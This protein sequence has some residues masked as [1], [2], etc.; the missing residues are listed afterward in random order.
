MSSIDNMNIFLKTF[1]AS[2]AFFTLILFAVL[3][4]GNGINKQAINSSPSSPSQLQTTPIPS[5]FV[6][7]GDANVSDSVDFRDVE[8]ISSNWNYSVGGAIDQY[9]DG[10]VNSL[11]FAVVAGKLSRQK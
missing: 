5:V 3:L 1:L 6:G 8:F 10:K 9:Q 7:N 11:D 2:F 4:A